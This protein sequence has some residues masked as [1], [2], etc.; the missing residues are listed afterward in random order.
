VG[1]LRPKNLEGNIIY[2]SIS[3][4]VWNKPSFVYAEAI[5]KKPFNYTSYFENSTEASTNGKITSNLLKNSNGRY[6]H[7]PA[8]NHKDFIFNLEKLNNSIIQDRMENDGLE[9]TKKI[10]R[11]SS[12]VGD[13]LGEVSKIEK[14][15]SI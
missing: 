10:N 1:F 7:S 4:E 6:I 14:L 11:I 3:E 12:R 2:V 9:L 8:I 13:I 15:A 5:S